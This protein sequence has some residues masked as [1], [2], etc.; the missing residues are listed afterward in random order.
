MLCGRFAPLKSVLNCSSDYKRPTPFT[1]SGVF[2]HA[3][4]SWRVTTP[5][6][7]LP[8][9]EAEKEEDGEEREEEEEEKGEGEMKRDN[10]PKPS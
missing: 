3:T 8:E 4:G 10:K 1:T 5:S 6:Q 9:K 2:I 7:S